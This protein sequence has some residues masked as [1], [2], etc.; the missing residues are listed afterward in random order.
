VL[1]RTLAVSPSGFYA[2]QQRPPS[3]R[4]QTDRGLRHAIRVIHAESHRRYGS[5]RVLAAVRALGHRVGRRRVMRL[6]RADGLC[7]R[8]R[9]R[10]VVTTESAP[11]HPVAR[12]LVQR[13]FRPSAPNHVWAADLTYLATDEGWLYLAVILD[14]YARR[15]V[16]WAVR[17]TLGTE[18]ALAALHMAL[19]RRHPPPGLI[20]H[21]D[22]GLQYTSAAYQHL[23]TQSGL[24][25]SMSRRGDCWDNAVVESFFS[26]LKQELAPA[27]WPTRATATTA[28]ARYIEAFYNPIRLHSTLG[29]ESPNNYEAAT[30]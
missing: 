9:R 2:A 25:S 8:R 3:A 30:T 14:L 4:A 21:S 12:N 10:F 6:M 17:A 1:C 13:A 27:T 28:I 16:G 22:R 29:Y 19:G 5:P 11:R 26:T 20:H 7:A 24:R 23:L 18:L 15:V